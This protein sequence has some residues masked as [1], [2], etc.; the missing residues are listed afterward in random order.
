MHER[1]RLCTVHRSLVIPLNMYDNVIHKKERAMVYF[2]DLIWDDWNEG[3]IA[4]HNVTPAEVEEVTANRPF[5]TRGRKDRYRLI[6]QTDSGRLLTVIVAPRGSGI[7]YVLTARE[8]TR[9]ERRA[10]QQH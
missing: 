8:A 6:G 2:D 4:R 1:Y 10:Y 7:A 5:T 9:E 3:H